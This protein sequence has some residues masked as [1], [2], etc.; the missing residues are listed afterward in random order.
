M[1]YLFL[2]FICCKTCNGTAGMST[3]GGALEFP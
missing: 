1:G 2:S 3:P